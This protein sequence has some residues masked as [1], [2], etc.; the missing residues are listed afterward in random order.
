VSSLKEKPNPDDV[1]GY[2]DVVLQTSRYIMPINKDEIN[3]YSSVLKDGITMIYGGNCKKQSLVI[4][5]EAIKSN[6]LPE[7]KTIKHISNGSESDIT[8]EDGAERYTLKDILLPEESFIGIDTKPAK[9]SNGL[10]PISPV[11]TI[12]PKRLFF[13]KPADM[14][15]KTLNLTALWQIGLYKWNHFRQQWSYIE[16]NINSDILSAHIR[17]AGDYV[18]F[19]DSI[20]PVFGNY[21]SRKNWRGENELLVTI[22][23]IG[24]GIN[25]ETLSV[26]VNKKAI[27][28]EYDPDRG[29]I[30]IPINDIKAKKLSIDITVSDIAQNQATYKRNISRRY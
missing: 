18:L 9:V 26:T 7:F 29:W 15:I 27:E 5:V 4:P 17:T 16:T 10:E 28:A 22:D 12:T 6:D 25:D 1:S 14:E 3:R 2:D 24:T 19:R 13:L 20:P 8:L 21:T 30:L 23:D 11:I